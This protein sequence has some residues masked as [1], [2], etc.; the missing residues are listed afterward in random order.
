MGGF[1]SVFLSLYL[2]VTLSI[3]PEIT[4]LLVSLYGLV[5]IPGLIIG[6]KIADKFGRKRIM[7]ISQIIMGCCLIVSGFFIHSYIS[8]LFILFAN[9]A[10]GITDPARNAMEGDLTTPDN[11][12]AAFSLIYQCMNIGVAIGPVMAGFLFSSHPQW[13]FWGNGCALL[14]SIS[15][16]YAFVPESIPKDDKKNK[17]LI[18]EAPVE[19]NM[20]DAIK[21]RPQ[22]IIFG[23]G[24][25]L[26]A[27]AY[28]GISFVIPIQL[29][30]LFSNDGS[31]IFGLLASLNAMLVIF[32]NPFML[33]IN[34]R[35][36]PIINILIASI[37]Y[38]VSFSLFGF[39]EKVFQFYLI[40]VC[41]TL[42]EM[43][44]NNNVN[45]YQFDNIPVNF[46][47][48]FNSI[49]PLFKMSGRMV[50]PLIGGLLLSSVSFKTFWLIDGSIM[51]I[52]TLLFLILIIKFE[53]KNV[54]KKEN[55]NYS[56]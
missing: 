32:I 11:R 31:R 55:P 2:S 34:R 27:L 7:V 1:V 13:L 5:Y 37:V 42:G 25:L 35:V 14:F 30:T 44:F 39:A 51:F 9:F 48:R 52:A 40:T 6:G 23:F 41:Y 22:L 45:A 16:V 4:G 33:T 17:Y 24:S 56:S 10:D 50:G 43:T 29:Q 54:L 3:E 8:I 36:R 19:G 53:R 21:A 47:G 38:M 18:K 26:T 28:K 20:L 15:I 49:M 46:R 12:Q